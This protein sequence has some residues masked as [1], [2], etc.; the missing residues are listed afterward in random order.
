MIDSGSTSQPP[1]L[2]IFLLN[3]G[4]KAK[5]GSEGPGIWSGNDF[6]SVQVV[7]GKNVLS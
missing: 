7:L 3:L 1:S 2:L 5:Q 4:Q 6:P